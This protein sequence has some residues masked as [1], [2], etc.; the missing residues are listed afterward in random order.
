MESISKELRKK[1]K[2]RKIRIGCTKANDR[3]KFKY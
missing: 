2:K 1:R 3:S